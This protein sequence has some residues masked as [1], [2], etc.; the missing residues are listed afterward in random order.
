MLAISDSV[1]PELDQVALDIKERDA[2]GVDV[3]GSIRQ[4]LH[5]RDDV[6]VTPLHQEQSAR[7]RQQ[8]P[9]DGTEQIG[10]RNGTAHYGT[11]VSPRP[12]CLDPSMDDLDILE[13]QLE[14]RLTDESELLLV[15]VQQPKAPVRLDD[16]Q[17]QTGKTGTGSEV[18]DVLA[19]EEGRD[20]EAVEQVPRDHFGRIADGGQIVGAV[21]MR[22]QIDEVEQT[23]SCR[24]VGR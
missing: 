5:V 20:R 17:R 24:L 9:V 19:E 3:Q 6:E 21:P 16:R 11:E 4:A 18:Q 13:P 15:A 1:T 23:L 12:V 2:Q 8:I 14:D 7:T 22:Q 10:R